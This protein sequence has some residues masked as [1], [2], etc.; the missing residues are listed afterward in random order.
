MKELRDLARTLLAD[1]AVKVVIG[2]EEGPRGV[3]PAFITRPEHAERLI[4]DARCTHCLPA[5]LSPRRTHVAALGKPAVVVKG[6]DARAVAGLIREAQLAREDVVVIGVRCGGVT[7]DPT[8]A[9][10]ASGTVAPRCDACDAREPKLADHVVGP[11]LPAPPA[12]DQPDMLARLEGMSAAERWEFWQEAFSRCVRCNA[13]R[14]ACP[15]CFCERCVADKTQPAWI[16]SS[17]HGRGNLAWHLTRAIHQA[18]RCVACGECQRACPADI[19]LG[20]LNKKLAHVVAERF[21]YRAGD[22][23]AVPAPVGAFRLDDAQE[24]IR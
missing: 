15:M 9:E 8:V 10:L 24:F 1:G 14:Q 22:D 11:A 18:G 7:G 16:E 20:L 3:R 19:P 12:S 13:C 5:Y 2:Y 23:P 17:P 21:G 6:C 4:F